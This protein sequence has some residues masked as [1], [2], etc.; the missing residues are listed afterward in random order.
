[1]FQSNVC[2]SPLLLYLTPETGHMQDKLRRRDV[3]YSIKYQSFISQPYN[4]IYNNKYTTAIYN[5][6]TEMAQN[7]IWFNKL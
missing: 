2:V 4:P 3:L 6:A 7:D 1:M 5:A